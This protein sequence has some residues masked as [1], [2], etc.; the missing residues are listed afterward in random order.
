MALLSC[1]E[2]DR[3]A[4]A[5]LRWSLSEKLYTL[6]WRASVI[7]HWGVSEAVLS[8]CS[9]ILI[10]F[11]NRNIPVVDQTSGLW[12][13]INKWILRSLL[14]FEL[15]LHSLPLGFSMRKII[16]YPNVFPH[17]RL[18]LPYTQRGSWEGRR[19]GTK[20]RQWFPIG[21]NWTGPYPYSQ[22][23]DQNYTT[24]LRRNPC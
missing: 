16:F 1:S 6:I 3:V 5:T 8:L 7:F 9:C 10:F 21:G 15:G 22:T 23:Y 20:R 13:Y 12:S 11:C 2:L 14:L 17:Q 24:L 4:I 19:G 18:K